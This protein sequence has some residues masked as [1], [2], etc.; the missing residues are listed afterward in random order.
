MFNFSYGENQVKSQIKQFQ[1]MQRGS[2]LQIQALRCFVAASECKA[3]LFAQTVA[4]T[5]QI[6]GY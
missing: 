3:T 6:L 4:F 5:N 1:E 2:D